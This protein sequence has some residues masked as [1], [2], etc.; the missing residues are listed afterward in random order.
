[1]VNTLNLVPG[2]VVLEVDQGTRVIFSHV[3]GV[4]SAADL[5]RY[6]RKVGQLED[7]F[8]GAFEAPVIM[9]PEQAP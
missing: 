6:Q 9:T 1:V 3:L 4:R 8:V 7:L 2:S 5:A